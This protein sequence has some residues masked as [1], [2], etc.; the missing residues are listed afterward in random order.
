MVRLKDLR[1][2]ATLAE[3]KFSLLQS[4]YFI[5]N[6]RILGILVL[7]V[8]GFGVLAPG[9]ISVASLQSILVSTA[10]FLLLALGETFVIISGGIDLS[11][12]SMLA[13]SGMVSGVFMSR[14]Y[15]NGS[16]TTIALLGLIIALVVGLIGGMLNGVVIAKLRLNPLIVTL[17]TMGIFE[18][19]AE[20]ISNGLPISNFPPFL[21][22]LGNGGWGIPWLLWF[23]IAAVLFY[24]LLLAKTRFGRYI[25]A[26]G[27]SKDA[28]VRAGVNT[29]IHATWLYGLA[30]LAAGL[31]GYLSAAHFETAS[32]VAGSQYLLI[33]VA[34]AV[35]GGTTLQ[36]GE[37][38]I[39][40]TVIGALIISVL[41]NGFVM[42][43]LASFWQLVAVGVMVIVA[44]FFN[45]L[46][47]RTRI[48]S[49]GRTTDYKAQ[50]KP[51]GRAG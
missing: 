50:R 23:T 36:G 44:V 26:Y 41:Q 34:A 29:T 13:M 46:Q 31:A 22:V 28:V 30:G 51:F 8:I 7:L 40:G 18:G 48:A 45:E 2:T 9:F 17:G 20:L 19:I 16:G 4:P 38:T 47:R 33:A 1:P 24:G 15:N 32:P 39:W 25:Y 37:G 5:S 11:I 6:I 3:S 42:I 49:A 43:G 27:A 35:I 14:Y 21:F 10:L 12:G